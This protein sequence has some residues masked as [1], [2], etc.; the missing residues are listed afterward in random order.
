MLRLPGLIDPHVHMRE[1]G[2]THKEDWTSGT[3]AALAGG[4]TAVLAM[5]NTAPPVTDEETLA[6]T[7]TLAGQKAHCD[8]AQYLGAGADNAS[9]L[10]KLADQAAGLKMYLDQTYGP[11]RLT[12]Q[13]DWRKHFEGWPSDKPLCIHAEGDTL[14]AALKLAVEI[15]RPVHFCHVSHKDEI[16]LIRA[17]KERGAPV[18]CEVTPHH[19]FLTDADIPAIGIGR[20]EVRPRLASAADQQALWDNLDVIDCFASDHAPHT[21]AE[22]DGINPPP[23]FPGLETALPLYL[24]A[25][26]HDLLCLEEL[27]DLCFTNPKRIFNLPDQPDTWIEVDENAVWQIQDTYLLSHASWSPFDDQ[28]VQGR[29]TRVVLRGQEVF[30][31]GQVLSEPGSGWDLRANIQ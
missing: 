3:A 25:V 16:L 20:S 2:A 7:L 15:N 5:P 19:L 6:Q 11:L 23:G 10:P 26:D 14:A 8:Y 21:L 31:D 4:F 29:V 1:P 22:K 17:A 9:S 13:A 24:K 27:I 28:L 30:K 12:D 18:T